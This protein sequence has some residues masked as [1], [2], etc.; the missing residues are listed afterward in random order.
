MI[1]FQEL[2]EDLLSSF[3]GVDFGEDTYITSFYCGSSNK[4]EFSRKANHSRFVIMNLE[5]YESDF[6]FTESNAYVDDDGF[7]NIEIF[8][9]TGQKKGVDEDIVINF[10]TEVSYCIVEFLRGENPLDYEYFC[11]YIK[12][13]LLRDSVC[14]SAIVA[15][16][17]F[18]TSPAIFISKHIKRY[19]FQE[20]ELEYY[21]LMHRVL[22]GMTILEKKMFLEDD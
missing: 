4:F 1:M 16:F 7:L 20:Q 12:S 19:F 3:K 8:I 10:L 22:S 15:C 21:N 2:I 14:F 18:N 13:D 11:E 17:Y 5:F 6:F 9:S